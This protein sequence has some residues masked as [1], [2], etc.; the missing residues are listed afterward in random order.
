[1]IEA[2][3]WHPVALSEELGTGAPAGPLAVTLLDRALVLWRDATGGVHAWSDHCPHRGAR[4]SLGR[5]RVVGGVP[6]GARLE[7][8]YHGWRFGSSGHADEVPALPGFV[9]PPT[10]RACTFEA[11]ERH[12][13]VWVRLATGD[14]ELPLFEAEGDARLRKLNCGPYDVATSAPRVVENFLDMAHFGF[15][16]DGSLGSRDHAGVPDHDVDDTATGLRATNCR[17]WQPLSSIH[18]TGG[19]MVDYG[20]AVV[21]PYTAVL[22]K[23]PEPGK[24]AV[25]DFREA[26]ALFVRPTGEV[27]SRVWFRLAMNDFIS[28]DETLR[29]FQDAVFAEDR[30]V[31]ESQ[32]PQ[33]LPLDP[34]AEL[35]S[36]ADK[37]S[38]A[39]R[40]YLRRLGVRFGTC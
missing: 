28:P 22:T 31:L 27:S 38:A 34:Q 20:Y 37:S 15:V 6:G 25:Q 12:G 1:M 13:L 16:H 24:A 7:C 11:T 9:P 8:P 5:V 32:R 3:H 35:H 36:A 30:P 40:R 19:A 18:A 10:H 39:Y 2:T 17:A 21:G 23:A 14:T 4:L 33:R 26:I 29:A